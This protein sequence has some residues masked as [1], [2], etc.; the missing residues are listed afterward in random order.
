M[1]L[2]KQEQSETRAMVKGENECK[3]Q[4]IGH[5]EECWERRSLTEMHF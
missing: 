4:Q 3:R 1:E 5:K 2:T